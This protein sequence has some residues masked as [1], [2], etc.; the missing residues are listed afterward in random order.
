MTTRRPVTIHDVAREAGVSKS[1]VSRILDERRPVSSSATAER[2]REAAQRLGYR[3]DASASA[4]RRQQTG[5]IGVLV[6]RLSDAVM[7]MFF[8]EV[9]RAC[10]DAARFAIVATTGDEP[11]TEAIAAETLLAQGVDGLVMTT[12]RADSDTTERLRRQGVP[13]VLALRTD[14][15][16]PASLCDD[17]LGGFLATRH[18]LDLQHRRIGLVAGPDYASS[19]LGRRA[20]H[21]R[22]LAEAG[23]ELDP[24]LVRASSFG[25]ESGATEA[26]A[27][28]DTADPPTAIF[29]IND[30][31]AV[32]VLAAAQQRGLSVPDDLSVVGYNDIPLSARLPVPLTTVHVPL[33][34][35]ARSAVDMLRTLLDGRPVEEDRTALPTLIPRSSTAAPASLRRR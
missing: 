26:G 6:P 3:R 7:A 18:L 8:E 31:T 1:T 27:L 25:M 4:L 23:V 29:A 28:L 9:A 5:T 12:A 10:R 14:G 16:T 24:A 30:N 17:E 19:A 2:V 34:Q 13:L 22:A 15:A 21:A 20:G 32:G 11:R 33:D 35:V